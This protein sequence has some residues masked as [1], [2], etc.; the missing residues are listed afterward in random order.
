MRKGLPERVAPYQL[1][2]AGGTLQAAIEIAQMRR[3]KGLVYE[4][5]G[6]PS[7]RLDVELNFSRGES[8]GYLL[9]GHVTG[10]LTLQC[11]RCMQAMQ[12]PLDLI[13][14]LRLLPSEAMLERMPPE[15]DALVAG[16]EDFKPR[17]LV[18]DEIILAL[19]LVPRHE[20]EADCDAGGVAVLTPDT[21]EE[22]RQQ[23]PN[24]FATLKKLKF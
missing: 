2:A 3:L 14:K 15:E 4:P 11:Q 1:A 9:S 19:P 10:T 24:P 18:E 5:N 13:L 23:R 17:E 6:K 20:G 7:G 8:G 16:D 12:W 21:P 22:T